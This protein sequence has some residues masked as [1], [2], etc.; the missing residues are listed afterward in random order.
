M[1]VFH[2]FEIVQMVPNAQRII[3]YHLQQ[4][5]GGFLNILIFY[6]H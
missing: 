4:S 1:G 2:G 6:L 3:N 5:R